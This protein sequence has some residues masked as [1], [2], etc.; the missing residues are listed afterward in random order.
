M[1]FKNASYAWCMLFMLNWKTFLTQIV[2][3]AVW[4]SV[5]GPETYR[6]GIE[7]RLFIIVTYSFSEGVFL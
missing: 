3:K 1:H 2:S 6:E 7:V 5:K 4:Q